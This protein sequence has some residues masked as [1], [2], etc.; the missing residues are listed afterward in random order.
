[1]RVKRAA[2]ETR[3][4]ELDNE[5]VAERAMGDDGWKEKGRGAGKR[6]AREAVER[7]GALVEGGDEMDLDEGAG[8]GRPKASKRGGGRLGFGKR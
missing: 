2:Q 6:G 7:D 5:K 3:R 4:R 8:R 1:M